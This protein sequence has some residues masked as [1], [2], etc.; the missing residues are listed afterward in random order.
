MDNLMAFSNIFKKATS[1]LGLGTNNLKP[2]PLEGEII[3]CKNNVCVHPPAPL[4]LDTEHHPGYLTLRSHTDTASGPTLIL[5]WIPNSTLKKNPK[6]IENSPNRSR[7]VT[8]RS[9][10]HRTPKQDYARSDSYISTPSTI[11]SPLDSSYSIGSEFSD[12]YCLNNAV[13]CK[14]NHIVDG[15]STNSEISTGSLDASQVG[16]PFDENLRKLS[17]GGKSQADS[18]IST[19]DFVQ[20]N[21]KCVHG[22]KKDVSVGLH[23]NY[24]YKEKFS[25]LNTDIKNLTDA[26]LED[27]TSSST[28][29]DSL[30]SEEKLAAML[31]RNK[32]HSKTKEWNDCSCSVS[33]EMEGDNLC[34]VTEELEDTQNLVDYIKERNIN[35]N[36]NKFDSSSSNSN[37]QS[38]DTE[39]ASLSSDSSC[40]SPSRNH[41]NKMLNE[42]R[43]KV[44]PQSAHSSDRGDSSTI[45][46][47]CDGLNDENLQNEGTSRPH[48][49][50]KIP[51]T[52]DLGLV[53]ITGSL[54]TPDISVRRQ[55]NSSSSTTTSGPDSE[56]PSPYSSSPELSL[57]EPE[58]ESLSS[59]DSLAHDLTFPENALTKK[60]GSKRK[61]AKEQVCGVFS[62]DLGQMRSLRLFYSDREKC[63][64]QIVIASRES[65]YK[66]LH[67]H[68]GGLDK[69]AE[70]FEDW[71]LFAQSQEKLSDSEKSYKQFMIVRPEVADDQC[72]PDEGVYRM[73]TEDIWKNH[74]MDDGVVEDDFQ[75]RKAI[76]FGGLD[77]AL[78]HEAWPYLLHY[79]PFSSTFEEREKIRNDKY[80]E[81]QNIRK[82]RE[83][84]NEEE[85][86]TFLRNI[87]CIVEK[88][89]V[90]TD[91]SH[92]YFRGENNPNIEILKNILLN[93]AV[94]NPKFGYTQG[95]SDL[96]APVLAEIQNE[97]DTYWCFEGLMQR[98]IFVSSPKDTDMDK[99]LNNLR[100]LLRLLEPKF[101]DHLKQLGDDAMELLFAHRWILLC[102]K[103]EF[104]EAGALQ[105]WESCWAHY[106]TDYFHLF[107]CVAIVS[108][109]G[110]DVVDQKLA[111]DEILLHFSSLA[112]HMNAKQVLRKAR[113]LL[114]QYRRRS[115]IPCTLYGLC[116]LCGQGMWDSGHVPTVECT[117]GHPDGVCPYHSTP[118]SPINSGV[119]G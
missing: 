36:E 116:S 3:Y 2:P 29:S 113:G 111:A 14:K 110:D 93:Y 104:S 103:R 24:L 31:N 96:L 56:P 84:M 45:H 30:T 74:L 81:Y 5:T 50:A 35:K 59:P 82:K 39:A 80:I 1:L 106:Q 64:G 65:Q 119:A 61:S 15:T 95:M 97:V 7:G 11:L 118:D 115:R 17:T 8:P 58:T 18:G 98:T 57:W 77:P 67:F 42:I 13:A 21:E 46:D 86:E 47:S 38:T 9:S 4:S 34:V 117:G 112:C 12:Q 79:Y 100:E 92:H 55:R 83:S 54:P 53:A 26:A 69:L 40:P 6:S 109:Y 37:S 43:E 78:R 101:Y 71:S 27:D 52:L 51:Q 107:I 60:N 32:L 73:V 19:E 20:N 66:I 70:I 94:A 108:I 16:A 89:V 87:Q 68:H 99:Q 91:R 48:S 75:L 28:A 88:D 63:T 44:C 62:V 76:F 114:Y 105:I 33:I 102:F 72:H 25:K 22:G 10:P 85:H 23:V 41:Y 90:R 49:G